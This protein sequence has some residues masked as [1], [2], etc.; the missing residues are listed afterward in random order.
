M[1]NNRCCEHSQNKSSGLDIQYTEQEQS[2]ANF[3]E[4]SASIDYFPTCCA[5]FLGNTGPYLNLTALSVYLKPACLFVA[6]KT[7][8]LT[9]PPC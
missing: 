4:L 3:L 8:P 5:H 7:A 9:S 2:L 1:R 6:Q